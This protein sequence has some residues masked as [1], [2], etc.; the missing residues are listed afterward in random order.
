M[1]WENFSRTCDSGGW[2][3][4][5]VSQRISSPVGIASIAWSDHRPAVFLALD[6]A[7]TLHAF[8]LLEN[9]SC[10]TVSE[11]C[12]VSAGIAS[13][14]AGRASSGTS[15]RK[16]DEKTQEGLPDPDENGMLR[17]GER[18]RERDP[19]EKAGGHQDGAADRGFVPTRPRPVLWAPP[20][21]ALSSETLATG[22]R[23]RVAISIG[24]R[25][26]MR[27]LSARVFRSPIEQGDPHSDEGAGRDVG[28][29][30][31]SSGGG[32][33]A[34][35]S[36]KKRAGERERMKDWLDSVF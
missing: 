7:G 2:P 22:S 24:G 21:M 19:E 26:F 18:S 32:G 29:R 14:P 12:P 1:V 13:T 28:S 3:G 20:G 5:G 33:G 10:P 6:S 27:G 16:E 4:E 25:T 36:G 34:G 35:G 17:S 9:D 11:P 30:S 8:D 15:R 23:P 31:N